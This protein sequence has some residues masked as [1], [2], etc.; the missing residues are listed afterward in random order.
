V[1]LVLGVC[2]SAFLLFT[3]LCLPRSAAD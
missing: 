1:V 3:I 2:G